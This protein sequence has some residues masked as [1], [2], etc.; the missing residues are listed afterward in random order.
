M[1]DLNAIW[2]EGQSRNMGRSLLAAQ[3]GFSSRMRLVQG[4]SR[5]TIAAA[6][7]VWH[8]GL[9]ALRSALMRH[10]FSKWA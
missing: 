1:I 3:E 10:L 8:S 2:A 5:N 9:P 7:L 4:A 6:L